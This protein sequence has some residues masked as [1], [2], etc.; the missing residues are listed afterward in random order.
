MAQATDKVELLMSIDVALLCLIMTIL[1]SRRSW[2]LDENCEA[3]GDPA[4]LDME[5]GCLK[6]WL[7]TCNFL[8]KCYQPLFALV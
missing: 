3:G 1:P 8:L 2:N 4:A 6:P 7:S 5:N